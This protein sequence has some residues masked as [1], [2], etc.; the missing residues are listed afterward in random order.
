MRH[1]PLR[2]AVGR[3]QQKGEVQRRTG[4]YFRIDRERPPVCSRP[5]DLVF[6][7]GQ[8]DFIRRHACRRDHPHP[9]AGDGKT[10]RLQ[11]P[12]RYRES[13]HAEPGEPARPLRRPDHRRIRERR[14]VPPV[15]HIGPGGYR[16][17]RQTAV[18]E[19][20]VN[21]AEF[22]SGR[23][24][25]RRRVDQIEPPDRLA[26]H[27]D[28]RPLREVPAQHHAVFGEAEA[29]R[30]LP[31]LPRFQ[32]AQVVFRPLIGPAAPAVARGFVAEPHVAGRGEVDRFDPPR[33]KLRL[34]RKLRFLKRPGTVERDRKAH[35]VG[36]RVPDPEIQ[37]PDLRFPFCFQR[38][39]SVPQRQPQL[40]AVP[41]ENRSVCRRF[42]RKRSVFSADPYRLPGQCRR[43]FR[44]D[45][46][47]QLHGER[48]RFN[49]LCRLQAPGQVPV[50]RGGLFDMQFAPDRC[51]FAAQ[52]PA[53]PECVPVPLR[54][55][56]IGVPGLA[57][58]VFRGVV[59]QSECCRAVDFQGAARR[60]FKD[61]RRCRRRQPKEC[62]QCFHT[63]RF[64]CRYRGM[65]LESST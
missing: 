1:H 14:T 16:N 63:I 35:R 37:Q 19:T 38:Q 23:R 10:D 24:R 46:Q 64:L 27:R 60:E 28:R 25:P 9:L 8:R 54:P 55:P 56:R 15:V 20:A 61:S 32:V 62:E 5:D 36:R 21:P 6:I 4:L 65:P 42:F 48:L 33:L 3:L 59:G 13:G 50:L 43:R 30:P 51:W 29:E 39:Q 2:F 34:Q 7:P 44:L 49:R 12:R 53:A 11:R 40:R 45:R 47:L 26:A 58:P 17:L 31:Q 52:L 57:G 18:G 22:G 41:P